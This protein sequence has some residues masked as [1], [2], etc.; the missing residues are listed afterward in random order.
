[1]I[2]RKSKLLLTTIFFLTFFQSS[3]SSEII[4]P[5]KKPAIKSQIVVPPLKPGTFNE[6]QS[7]KGDKDL[8]KEVLG[9]FITSQKTT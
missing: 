7:L 8:P 3:Y 4:I 1:M 9:I 5:K 2:F 6:K